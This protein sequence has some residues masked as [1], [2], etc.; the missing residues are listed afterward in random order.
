MIIVWFVTFDYLS[1]PQSDINMLTEMQDGR[2]DG[3]QTF[4]KE[5]SF[6]SV[7]IEGSIPGNAGIFTD[8]AGCSPSS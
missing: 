1:R 8:A 7:H 6:I 3:C 2:Q 4:E 5:P